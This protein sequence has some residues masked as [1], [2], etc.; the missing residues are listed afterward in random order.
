M[1]SEGPLIL[2][3]EIASAPC[4]VE[5]TI[6]VEK[7]QQTCAQYV[8]SSLWLSR[9]V[10]SSGS[11]LL[12]Y[13]HE[14]ER[15]G[16]RRRTYDTLGNQIQVLAALY[17]VKLEDLTLKTGIEEQVTELHPEMLGWKETDSGIV[18]REG[19]HYMSLSDLGTL[20]LVFTAD[21][22]PPHIPRGSATS[23]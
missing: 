14:N 12:I 7:G 18:V 11:P 1:A 17:G 5:L 21:A 2:G 20:A 3:I 9:G 16:R 15:S 23:G 4:D 13:E 6:G 8:C 19:A 10:G 22:L